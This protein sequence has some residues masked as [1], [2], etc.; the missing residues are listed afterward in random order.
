VSQQFAQAPHIEMAPMHGETILFNPE[1]NKF[2][3][4]NQTAAFVWTK[5]ENP[6]TADALVNELCRSF[7]SASAGEVEK[8]VTKVLEE[9]QRLNFVVTK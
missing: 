7:D 8:D 5:L 3:V 4:L 9:M 1:S 2:C 6:S